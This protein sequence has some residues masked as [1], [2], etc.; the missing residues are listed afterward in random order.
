MSSQFGVWKKFW[1][2]AAAQFF[3]VFNDHAF[4]IVAIFAAVGA[5]EEYSTNTAFLAILTIF[6]ALPFILFPSPAGYFS[7][8]FPKRNVIVIIKIVEL[9][10]MLCGTVCLAKFTD[11][12]TGPLIL[13]MF[14]LA[15]QSTFFSPALNGIL[16]ETFSEKE[17]SHVNGV[18]EM[19]TMLAVIFGMSIGILVK[20]LSG[21]ELY[22]CGL[23]FSCL[24]ITALIMSLKIL[25]GAAANSKTTWTWKWFG[26]YA[27]GFKIVKA[28]R[29]VFL[30]VLGDS[31][32]VGIGTAIQL[33]LL[34][35][36]KYNLHLNNEI[37]QGIIQLTL[38]LGIGVGCYAAGRI[39][40]KKVELGL[41]PFGA[42]G[43]VVFLVLAVL[44][45]GSPVNTQHLLESAHRAL[46]IKVGCPILPEFLN[47]AFY[48]W[49]TLHLI[50]LGLSGGLFMVPLRAYIQNK[51]SATNRGTVLANANVIAFASI[52]L[53][54]ILILVCCSGT[55]A[56]TAGENSSLLST[57]QEYFF[58]F[59]PVSIFI[60]LSFLTI[61]VSVYACWLLP[62]FMVR[63]VVVILTSTVYKIR[64]EGEDNIPEHGPA[65]LIAN[66][67]SFVDGLLI[68]A[69]SSRFVRF[70]M[71]EDYY[72]IPI[73]TKLFSWS[74]FIAIPPP[75][76]PKKIIEALNKTREAL[77]NGDVVCI[78]P[79]G[80]IT[81][82]GV[83]DEFKHGFSRMIPEELDVPVIPV[84]LG[85]LWGSIFS[86]YYGKIKLR[87][88]MELPHPA[89]VT[90]GKPVSKDLDAFELRQILSELAAE[91]ES[92]PRPEERPVHYQFAKFARRHP[93]KKILFDSNGRGMNN[94]NVVTRGAILSREIRRLC[95]DDRKYV[96]ILLPNTVAT[97]VTTLAVMMAD[98]VPAMLN[99]TASAKNMDE[100]VKKANL[101]CILTSKIFLQ[102]AGIEKRPEM[103]FLEDIAKSIPK[104][105]IYL[106]G[107]LTTVMP[108]QELM[109]LLAPETHRNVFATAVLLFSSGSTGNP[110]G[111][112]LSHHNINSNVYSFYRIMGWDKNEDSILG[113]LPLFHSFGMTACFWVPLMTG[114]RVVYTPNPLD[115]A[116][117]GI[118]IQEHKIRILLATPT[119]LQ[120]YMKKC[121]REQFKHLR[122]VIVGAEKLRTDIANR[123]KE[124]TGLMPLEGYGCT[125]LAPVV[126]VNISNSILSLGTEVGK[127]GSVGMPMPGIC[128]KIVDPET[129]KD[130]PPNT[131]GLLLVK[132]P[133]VMQG[134]LNDPEK[135]ADVIRDGWYNTG[136]IAKVDHD[137]RITITGRL[138]RFSKIGG[139]MV[140]H[141]LV[142]NAIQEL[143]ETDTRAVAVSSAPDESK[144]E[145]LIV[146]YTEMKFPPEKI[147]A[148][149]REAGLPNL[150]IPRTE[151]FRKIEKFPLLGSGKLDLAALKKMIV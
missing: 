28:N 3:G 141:E 81:R 55:G 90:I 25:P 124:M 148:K 9:F 50:F 68:T 30:S 89:S 73:L 131:E 79:E 70:L 14:L 63:F 2:M 33:L 11:W 10:I 43:I 6:Y 95:P 42:L 78:F 102:K 61:A 85:M 7:D 35:F 103:V 41:V 36:A 37:E 62:E 125:E 137:D 80:K 134:Y 116:A 151:N 144:G 49:M 27:K 88:P 22:K 82:N 105:K 140:P 29:A 26:E 118:A 16:P 52:I 19:V 40:G 4:K 114:T 12:G 132:G 108:H 53:A 51:T 5:S 121:T 67:V 94:F 135:T 91:T 60:S 101:N 119:L 96:G 128:V 83:M 107:F 113:N 38:A 104:W 31:F 143:L 1:P 139:E 126:S 72:K 24:S 97:T 106:W 18:K 17:I 56:G 127:P 44:C 111:V 21:D 64:L 8:R 65:L 59:K 46:H 100:A 147:P 146:F 109:N 99:Y 66:H 39:S 142:E 74:G 48:P 54:G 47:F 133:T 115:A 92:K 129:R 120:M 45:T 20:K 15:A 130:L 23:F 145:K 98:K 58:N 117:T 122:L 77:R 32:F 149:L 71:Y 136:D 75:D 57:M 110:K 150:W 123:F 138:S 13:V 87:M 34:V 86:Y 93:F 84:R 69:C 76:K 112:M